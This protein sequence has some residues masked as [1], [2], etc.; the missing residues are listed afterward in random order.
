LLDLLERKSK[1]NDEDE[2]EATVEMLDRF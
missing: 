2:I 1:D